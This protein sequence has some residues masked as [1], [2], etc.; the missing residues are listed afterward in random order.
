[1][2]DVS[3]I[4]VQVQDIQGRVVPTSQNEVIF[5]L[6]GP[7]RIIG[8]GNGDPS[9]HEAERFIEQITQVNIDK[10][11]V[12]AL[13]L[14]ERYAE[15]TP[16][17]DDADW[18]WLINGKGE[19]SAP[20]IDSTSVIVIRG[21]FLLP[22]LSQQTAVS[23]WPKSLGE[24]Q[25]IYVNGQCITGKIRRRDA[26]QEY[27]LAPSIL[28]V[29]ENIFALV[30]KPLMKRFQYDNLNTDPGIIQ[31]TRPADQWRRKVFNGLAQVIVQSTKTPG[32]IVVQA[33]GEGLKPASVRIQ[34]QQSILRPS[35][36]EE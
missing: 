9:S 31:T 20:I 11:K 6:Q 4:T 29:G 16:N 26:V 19:Y 33:T 23:L 1:M 30:G 10:L 21:E 36:P 27:S 25:T 34:S 32:M 8:V 24:E 7:G 14:A 17:Y 13:P 35:I 22:A 12:K 28:H 3:V 15:I 2:E 5:S 18:K